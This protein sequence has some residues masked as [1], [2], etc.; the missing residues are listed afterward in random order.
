MVNCLSIF[1]RDRIRDIAVGVLHRVLDTAAWLHTAQFF[2]VLGNQGFA[3]LIACLVVV[4]DV[5][6][7]RC[8]RRIGA[9]RLTPDISLCALGTFRCL[10]AVKEVD[11]VHGE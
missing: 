7:D 1:I 9:D 4:A 11:K 2:N 5:E 3:S 6:L 8:S 10:L